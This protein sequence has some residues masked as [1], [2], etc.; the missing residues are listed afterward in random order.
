[1]E[2]VV[3]SDA[4]TDGGPADVLV[5]VLQSRHHPTG[6]PDEP[7]LVPQSRRHRLEDLLG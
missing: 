3:A 1:M 7:V 6:V 5:L 2:L 4:T